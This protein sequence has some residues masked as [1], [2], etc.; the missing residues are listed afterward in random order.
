VAAQAVLSVPLIHLS[1]ASGQESLSISAGHQLIRELW[2]GGTSP[3]FGMPFPGCPAVYPVLAA[4]ADGVGGLAAARLMSLVCMLSAT[5]LLYGSGRRL[6][7]YWPGVAG[8]GLL[9]ALGIAHYLGASATPGALALAL[10]AAAAYAAVRASASDRSAQRWLLYVPALLL[11]ANTTDYA[12]LAFDPLMIGVA[13]ALLHD[14]GWR[15]MGQRAVALGAATGTAIGLAVILAGASCIRAVWSATYGTGAGQ[16]GSLPVSGAASELQTFRWI[17]LAACLAAASVLAALA[18]GERYFLPLLALLALA[19]P[20]AT[21]DAGRLPGAAAVATQDGFA[22]WFACLA[23]GYLAA[24]LAELTRSGVARAL[25]A[26]LAAVP[27]TLAGLAG[28]AQGAG[29]MSAAN[30]AIPGIQE[31]Q[32]LLR[33]GRQHYLISSYYSISYELRP[34]PSSQQVTAADSVAYPVPG[35]PATLLHGT[36]GLTAAIDARWFA[37]VSLPSPFSVAWTAEDQAAYQACL[38]T[39]GYRLIPGPAG[40]IFVDVR[41]YQRPA[42]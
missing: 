34:A 9:A 28:S 12:S 8:A 10:L 17:G 20:L 29:L 6:F 3:G 30:A 2:H 38:A 21:A 1:I 4:I 22:A 14:H 31:L 25:I 26:G 11:A 19:T 7:G 5:L 33:P 23:A 37:L 35:R 41:D 40:A 24:R 36:A 32:P 15:R 42:R 39:P 16:F 18:L 13:A 27:P